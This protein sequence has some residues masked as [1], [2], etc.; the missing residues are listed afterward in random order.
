MLPASESASGLHVV[1]TNSGIEKLPSP[2]VNGEYTN[3]EALARM[4]EGSG[5][6]YHFAGPDLVQLELS[7]VDESVTVNGSSLELDQVSSAKNTALAGHAAIGE[8]EFRSK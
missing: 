6:N 4:L 5:A 2:G 1:I 3:Q 8:R 7:S